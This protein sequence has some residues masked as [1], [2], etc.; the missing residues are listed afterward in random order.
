MP[1]EDGYPL[2]VELAPCRGS[3]DFDALMDHVQDIWWASDHLI[4]EDLY[5]WQISTGGWSGNEDIIGAL[6]EN[7]MF[8]MFCWKQSTRGGHYVFQ[9]PK[10]Q[11]EED[12]SERD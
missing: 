12:E 1:D 4:T 7:T 9:T 3:E 6:K 5:E 2:E 10:Q 8:W 11:R